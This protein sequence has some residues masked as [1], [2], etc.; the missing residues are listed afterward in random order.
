[1]VYKRTRIKHCVCMMMF[2]FLSC[3]MRVCFAD[4]HNLFTG[5]LRDY[6]TDDGLVN[7]KGLYKDERLNV[8]IEQLT[9]TDPR[10]FGSRNDQLA[11]WINAYN[12]Y[13]LKIICDNYPLNSINDLHAGGLIIGT[14]FKTTIWDKKLVAIN[15]EKTTLNTIEHKIIRPEFKDPRI[16]FALVCAAKGCPPL[17]NEAYRGAKLDDQLNDQGKIFLADVE[18]NFFDTRTNEAFLSSIFSWYARDFG[19]DKEARLKFIAQFL[20][21]SVA[22]NIRDDPGR[23]RIRYKKYDWSLNEHNN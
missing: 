22:N 5:I 13:T 1:M 16:H 14:V 3:A 2:L 10:K 19:T 17:R 18:N 15:N 12:A 20:P 23:W 8:Y 9:R 7:Y 11:F 4:E 6:V 21:E